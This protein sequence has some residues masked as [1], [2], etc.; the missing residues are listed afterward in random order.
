MPK[1]KPWPSWAIAS[2]ASGG[3][4]AV[5]IQRTTALKPPI[6][7]SVDGCSEKRGDSAVGA[8]PPERSLDA[9]AGAPGDAGDGSREAATKAARALL[10]DAQ[11]EAITLALAAADEGASSAGDDSASTAGSAAAFEK[12]DVDDAHANGPDSDGGDPAFGNA[13]A[14]HVAESA[15]QF[16]VRDLADPGFDPGEA[17]GL[18]LEIEVRSPRH[19]SCPIPA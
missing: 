6:T 5:T 2:S 4:L 10:V 3:S 15:G 9:L 19:R 12:S 7:I 17:I 1:L 8:S 13:M 16:R 14:R 18:S 11:C